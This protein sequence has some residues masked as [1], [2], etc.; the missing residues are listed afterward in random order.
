MKTASSA[1]NH[2]GSLDYLFLIKSGCLELQ[3]FQVPELDLKNF[4]EISKFKHIDKNTDKPTLCAEKI[5]E[6]KIQTC[7]DNS[8]VTRCTKTIL[9]NLDSDCGYLSQKIQAG[10][11]FI[12]QYNHLQAD[13]LLLKVLLHALDENQIYVNLSDRDQTK[14]LRKCFH[15]FSIEEECVV[16]PSFSSTPGVQ[17]KKEEKTLLIVIFMLCKHTKLHYHYIFKELKNQVL[18]PFT[19]KEQSHY[20]QERSDHFHIEDIGDVSVKNL[21]DIK[22]NEFQFHDFF[23][24]SAMDSVDSYPNN[25]IIAPSSNLHRAY[26]ASLNEKSN[27]NWENHKTQHA[28]D[29]MTQDNFSE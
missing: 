11:I 5:S 17:L 25:A 13:V 6:K 4:L 1:L 27:V 20:F 29:Q 14:F 3:P 10:V 9:K 23:Q 24:I 16:L 7:S 8:S 19:N 18:I 22:L 26:G 21:P 15:I 28:I 12:L 2:I